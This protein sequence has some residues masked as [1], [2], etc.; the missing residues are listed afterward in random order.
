MEFVKSS[1][2]ILI[3]FIAFYTWNNIPW[4]LC[5]SLSKAVSSNLGLIQKLLTCKIILGYG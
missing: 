3:I 2:L 1:I 4:F 5:F